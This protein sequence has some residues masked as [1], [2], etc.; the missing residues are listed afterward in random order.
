MSFRI[1]SFL[2]RLR[3]RRAPACLALLAGVST[4]GPLVSGAVNKPVPPEVLPVSE[5]I[6]LVRAAYQ[7]QAKPEAAPVPRW[8]LA[9]WYNF[10]GNSRPQQYGV[11]QY[12][13]GVP[14]YGV[15]QY[16]YGVPQYGVPQYGYGV[17]QYGVPQYGYGVPQYGLPP[18]PP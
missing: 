3:S 9:Q 13:Y 18:R 17:P 14:Q 5:R 15:P 6:R 7:Q 12:G 2:A 11:P 1:S 16:G 10:V 4:G 8:L